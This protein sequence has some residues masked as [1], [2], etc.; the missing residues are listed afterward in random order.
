MS[1]ASVKRWANV[2]EAQGWLARRR[3]PV[4]LQRAGVKTRYALA[5]P[6]PL[7]SVDND[8]AWLTE[9]QEHGSQ[10][11][12]AMAQGEPE[13]K[14][15]QRPPQTTPQRA[16]VDQVLVEAAEPSE[17]RGEGISANTPEPDP[18][19]ELVD[20][21]RALRPGW[22]DVAIRAA[23]ATASATGRTL[24]AIA[25]ELRTLAADPDTRAPGRLNAEGRQWCTRPP[26]AATPPAVAQRCSEPGHE[27]AHLPCALCASEVAAGERR[28]LRA[29]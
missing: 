21:V 13:K 4:E 2:L 27:Y 11:A 6:K 24:P 8:P 1:T 7:R 12:D 26:T 15:N 14:S 23:I 3:A 29:V 19:V 10:R 25:A 28:P 5:I 9:S 16:S 18:A 22:T 20:A 17:N